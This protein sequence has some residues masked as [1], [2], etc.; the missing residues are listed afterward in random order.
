MEIGP[1][2]RNCAS[3]QPASAVQVTATMWSVKNLPK[4]GSA[5]ISAR[6]ASAA[7]DG[8]A[9]TAKVMAGTVPGVVVLITDLL[10]GGSSRGLEDSARYSS[11]DGVADLVR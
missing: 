11:R 5:R 2:A 6:R 1:Y 8:L 9:W 3:C 4:P 7:G 10:H